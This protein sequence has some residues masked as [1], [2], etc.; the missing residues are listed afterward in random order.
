MFRRLLISLSAAS[1][2]VASRVLRGGATALKATATAEPAL[3]LYRDTNGWCP[4]CER[5]WVAL[6]KKGISYEEKLINLQDKPE[7]YKEI[8]PTALVPAIEFHDATYDSNKPGSGRLIWESKDILEALD[9]EFATTPLRAGEKSVSEVADVLNASFGFVYGAR[10]ATASEIALKQKTF[11][12]A[13]D[14]L[15]DVL[16]A[17]GPFVRGAALSAADLELAP[18][19]ERFYHQL[20]ILRPDFPALDAGRPGLAAWFAAMD[21]EPAYTRRVKGDPYS[22]TAVTSSF[23]RFFASD[24]AETKAK[25][26]KADAAAAEML[27]LSLED[28]GAL[29]DRAAV[30]EASTVLSGNRA[31]V[32]RD[33]SDKE[34]RTQPF[35]ARAE[36]L[37]SA[38]EAIDA[39]LAALKPRRWYRRRPRYAELSADAKVAAACIAGR[40]CAPRDMG[41]PA[42]AALRHVLLKLAE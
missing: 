26:E 38:D 31:A 3:T 21:A 24:D 36:A 34:P 42:C 17:S 32:A 39:A 37:A 8:V 35:I 15:D 12:A 18:T 16:K 33:A 9:E 23:L 22:W 1:A 4:F 40:L 19:M 7:W 13:L 6:E 14:Q 5:V 28:A 10:N 29:R 11:T 27:K 2:L 25:I 30:L 20:A 41:A